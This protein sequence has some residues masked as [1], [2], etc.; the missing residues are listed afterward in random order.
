M[1]ILS[2]LFGVR[3][4][5]A[6]VLLREDEGFVDLDIPMITSARGDAGFRVDCAGTIKGKMVGFFATFHPDWSRTDNPDVPIF[7]G[8]VT[9]GSTGPESDQFVEVLSDLYG[10]KIGGQRMLPSI[11]V[12]A[13]ALA[14]DPKLIGSSPCKFKLF[15]HDDD[16]ERYAEL[17]LNVDVDSKLV[18]FHEKDSEYRR[19]IVRG[20]TER[21]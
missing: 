8:K 9:I 17:F 11:Q 16:E 19:N 4:Q 7:F 3:G 5:A 6:E 15:F 18:Q 14:C 10:E 21:P 13:A 20:L 2:V 1:G 12:T